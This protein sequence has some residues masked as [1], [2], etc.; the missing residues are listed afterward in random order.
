MQHKVICASAQ[1]IDPIFL[2]VHIFQ[3]QSLHP[4]VFNFFLLT[5]TELEHLFGFL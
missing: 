1:I 2:N 4:F 3:G 5:V